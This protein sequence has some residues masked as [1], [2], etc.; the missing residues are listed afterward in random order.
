[1]SFYWLCETVSQYEALLVR[2]DQDAGLLVFV[3]F[4]SLYHSAN[5]PPRLD[6]VSVSRL[7][8]SIEVIEGK[9]HIIPVFSN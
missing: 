4:T 1:M 3:M 7:W 9:Q 5:T 2:L 6:C 8:F